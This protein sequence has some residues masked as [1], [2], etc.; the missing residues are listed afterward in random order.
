[1][2]YISRF[3]GGLTAAVMLFCFTVQA[4]AEETSMDEIVEKMPAK[5]IAVAECTTG[6]ML[7]E[8]NADEPLP[9]SHLA[10]LML[11]LL[12]AEKLED[13][14]L[15]MDDIVTVSANANEMPAPQVWLD[16]SEKISVEELIKAL[17]VG[18]ANDAAVALAEHIYGNTDSAVYEMNCKAKLLDMQNTAFS[19]V[20]GIDVSTVS[21][22]SDIVKLAAEFVKYDI[23]TPYFCSW[24]DYIRDGKAELVNRNRLVRSYKGI[25]GMKACGSENAG[26]CGVFTAEKRGMKIAVVVLGCD[27]RDNLEDIAKNLI[28]SCYDCFSVY[29]PEVDDEMTKD[30]PVE[31]GEK[32]TVPV[33]FG[34]MTPVLIKKG[35]SKDFD[36]EMTCEEVLK[37]PIKKGKC[38]GKLVVRDGEDT[39]FQADLLTNESV[40]EISFAFC[41]RKMLLYFLKM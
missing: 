39:V 15:S 37:A 2:L 38:C 40:K 34:E 4:S 9:I 17:T 27:S 33:T 16:K 18:N 23:L 19:D 22:T 5:S 30:L 29:I 41:L 12:T 35:S 7:Y 26:E 31:G 6:Q 21:S 28:D 24:L 25:T 20:C 1:M 10:K 36:V 11:L 32:R 3:I 8:K 14:S 13:G